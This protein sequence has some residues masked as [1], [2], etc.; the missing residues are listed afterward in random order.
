MKMMK[1]FIEKVIILDVE[2]LI[3]I[4]KRIFDVEVK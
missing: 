4:M 1:I 3:E 2:K